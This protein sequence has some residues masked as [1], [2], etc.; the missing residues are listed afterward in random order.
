MEGTLS[1]LAIQNVGPAPQFCFWWGHSRHIDRLSVVP[2]PAMQTVKKGLVFG[3][4][5]KNSAHLPLAAENSCMA[6]CEA[7]I[8]WAHGFLKGTKCHWIFSHDFCIQFFLWQKKPWLFHIGLLQFFW[9]SAF[10]SRFRMA[11]MDFVPNFYWRGP[12]KSQQTEAGLST[13]ANLILRTK[14]HLDQ[15]I[16][17][18][19]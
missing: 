4:T 5:T 8:P 10:F 15:Y 17:G 12:K 11:A 13:S 3:A 2:M 19:I 7:K 16:N 14:L 18:N 1:W 6:E 9:A